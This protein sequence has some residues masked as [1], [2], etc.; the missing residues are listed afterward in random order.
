MG[1]FC[2]VEAAVSWG[3]QDFLGGGDECNA[4]VDD[5][6]GEAIESDVFDVS[7]DDSALAGDGSETNENKPSW[8]GLGTFLSG[9]GA[10]RIKK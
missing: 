3:W 2:K 7:W 1:R 8:P 4:S 10:C 5:T 6:V 9:I